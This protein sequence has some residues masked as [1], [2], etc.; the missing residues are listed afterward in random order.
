V[1]AD[2]G[3]G[4]W[5]A[6]VLSRDYGLRPEQFAGW[7]GLVIL[8]SG[9]IGSLV[10]GFA[11]DRGQRSKSG[12]GILLG[13]VFAAWLSIPGAFFAL[14]P[15]TGSFALLLALLLGCGAVTGLVASTAV[16]VLVPNEIRG[17]C[18]GA[19]IVFG[20]IIGLG[21]A[22][23]LVTLVSAAMGGEQSLRYGLTISIGTTSL[24]AAVG[25]MRAM[26]AARRPQAL[27]QD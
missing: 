4:I 19:F 23:T 26:R 16:A 7:M 14:A 21:V 11:A 22:P 18:L 3:A 25:F 10:G 20:A 15:G 6:P 2:T 24:V 1:M 17:L 12:G 9:I 27:L 8:G 13:A 5:A